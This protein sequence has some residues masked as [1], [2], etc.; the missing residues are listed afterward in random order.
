M[1]RTT[2]A[3]SGGGLF[4]V[5]VDYGGADGASKIAVQPD[6]KVVLAGW[7]DQDVAVSRVTPEQGIDTGFGTSGKR[8]YGFGG[9][10]QGSDVAIEPEREDR[11]GWLR[12][13]G[14]QHA[15]HAAH[16]RPARWTTR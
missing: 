1:A 8:T 5:H 12:E 14:K 3:F 13:R 9:N 16:V 10:D 4:I 6:G 11:R 15:R 2:P 7:T